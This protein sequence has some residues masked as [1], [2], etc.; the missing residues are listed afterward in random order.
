[1]AEPNI[2][3]IKEDGSNYPDWETMKLGDISKKVDRK[4]SERCE[5]PVMMISQ[6]NGFIYQADKYSRENAGQS[7]KKYTLLKRGEFAYNHGA[8]KAKPYGVTYIL[9]EE[10]VARVPFVYHTFGISQGIPEY[11]NYA[12]NTKQMDRQLKKLVSSGVRMDGL[13]NISYETYMDVVINT[14]SL[15]EQQKIANSLNCLDE[16]ISTSEEEVKN[17]ESQK[18]AVMQ[19]IFSQDVRFK[20]EDGSDYEE[21]TSI[22]VSELGDIIGGGTPPTKNEAYWAGNIP[23]ISS[24][25]LDE[26]DVYKVRMSRFIT[27]DAVNNSAAKII[28]ENAILIVTRVGVGK[29]AKA[30]CKMC[31]SQDYM[32]IANSIFNADYL[33]YALSKLMIESKSN[34]RGTSIKGIPIDEIKTYEIDIPCHEE[35]Q[36]IADFL[37]TFD[38]AITAAKQEL[39]KWK[40]LKKGLLQQMFV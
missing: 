37:S 35:Q 4:S 20:K 27:E 21:W 31:T 8:S 6:G 25:D 36:F 3:F 22:H 26:G 11:W 17:L 30:P 33:L 10:D 40:E 23:W 32:S 1:M 29:V 16:A 24:A 19:K 13:L 12:L 15:E 7:L 2:R 28:P 18:K 9:S 38:E 14:P 39:E 34:V 5:A